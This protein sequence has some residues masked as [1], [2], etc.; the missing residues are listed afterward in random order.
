[1]SSFAPFLMLLAVTGCTAQDDFEIDEAEVFDLEKA[2]GRGLPSPGTG[3]PHLS[4]DS[5]AIV[6]FG[7]G[8]PAYRVIT[9]RA[10]HS[11]VLSATATDAVGAIDPRGRLTLG[12]RRLAQHADGT[13]FWVR[14]GQ[15]A[16]ANGRAE[17]REFAYYTRTYLVEA[18]GEATTRAQLLLSCD[19]TGQAAATCTCDF[20]DAE[21]GDDLVQKW[22]D[23]TGTLTYAIELDGTFT[24]TRDLCAGRSGCTAPVSRHYGRYSITDKM[25]VLDFNRFALPSEMYRYQ[26]DC[27]GAERLFPTAD[28]DGGHILVPIE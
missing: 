28:S 10:R 24:L 21:I 12:L 17:L 14:V 2:D 13:R 16:A 27:R 23:D 22:R 6:S 15:A 26:R 18:S 19:R 11:F 4:K 7:A 1:M 5:P 8:H 9:I 25:L 20:S 3:A